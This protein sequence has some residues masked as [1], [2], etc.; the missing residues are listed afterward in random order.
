MSSN[1]EWHSPLQTT[2]HGISIPDM[3]LPLL[4]KPERIGGICGHTQLGPDLVGLQYIE[5]CISLRRISNLDDRIS[6]FVSRWIDHRAG[7]CVIKLTISLITSTSPPSDLKSS[8]RS[9]LLSV[10]CISSLFLLLR[11]GNMVVVA[12]ERRW[13]RA[14]KQLSNGTERPVSNEDA[15]L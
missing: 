5:I 1:P 6:T 3:L 9:C 4:P 2:D 12:A 14:S 15:F 7:Y 11:A 8:S 10:V 13:K